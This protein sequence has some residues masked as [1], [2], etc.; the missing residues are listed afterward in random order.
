MVSLLIYTETRAGWVALAVQVVFLTLLMVRERL[1]KKGIARWNRHKSLAVGSAVVLLL[2]MINLGPEGFQWGLGEIADEAATITDFEPGSAEEREGGDENIALRFAIWRNTIEMIKDR[3]LIGWGLGN[4]KVFYPL[5]HRKAVEEKFFSESAQL[6]NAHNDYVQA[7][8][9]LGLVGMVLLAWL[10]L[11]LAV[12]V[13]RLTSSKYPDPIRFWAISIAVALAGLGVN[14]FFSFPFQRSIPPLVFMIFLGTLGAFYAKESTACYV[15]RR[16]WLLVFASVVV[17]VV[18]IW[19]I[20]FHALGIACDRHFMI[21][22]QLEKANRWRGVVLEG[23]RA[24]Q[25]NPYRTKILSYLGR[26]HVEA[27]Q[28]EEGIAALEKVIAAYPY[29]MNAL[30]NI[31]VA[32]GSIG[33]YE[34]ALEAY[35]RVLRIKPDYAKVHNNMGNIYM[36]QK[37]ADMAT[38]AFRLAAELNPE[39]SVILFNLG[40]AELHIRRYPEAAEAYEKAL[41][42]K[43]RWALAHKSL[44]AVYVNYLNRK[45]DGVAHLKKA[46]ALDPDMKDAA[47]MRRVIDRIEGQ[48]Q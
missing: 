3:P 17:S 26:A 38:E 39:N 24:K 32:Y 31:G 30:L 2:V 7:F 13:F 41:K 47:K 21:M 46:L 40:T 15:I 44:G 20:R 34:K 22:T 18:W 37:K 9:E 29:H 11:V 6:S 12:M 28:H 33:E 43:P 48:N 27:G 45:Q 16:R 19:M 36:K 5:Y 35:D 8:A 23:E 25:Y 1:Q 42:I 4:H 14:A 10:V